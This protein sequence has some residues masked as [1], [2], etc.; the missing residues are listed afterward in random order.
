M[1]E[2]RMFTL[3]MIVAIAFTGCSAGSGASANA[4]S[5]QSK[6]PGETVGGERNL[7]R[8][9]NLQPS[10]G[11]VVFKGSEIE[12]KNASGMI[13]IYGD[14]GRPWKVI[15]HD[16]DSLESLSG[17]E[18]DFYPLMFSNGASRDFEI[19]MRV[20]RQAKEWIEVV[21]HEKREPK[22]LGYVK[23]DDPL[24]KLLTWDGWVKDHFN[25]RFEAVSNPVLNEPEGAKKNTVIPDE[26]LIKPAEVKGD[27]VLIRWTKHEPEELT[28][29]EIAKEFPENSGWIRWRKDGEIMINEF[30]P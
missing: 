6:Q 16:D 30:Y 28:A 20:V 5:V 18:G 4:N 21:V 22:T 17:E 9:S 11:V 29:E 8:D 24:F 15:D 14:D 2:F 13:T 27:W 26:P 12:L 10:D 25:I 19:E 7:P 3:L 23:A 1:K